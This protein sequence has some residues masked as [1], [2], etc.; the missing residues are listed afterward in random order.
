MTWG[1]CDDG[2]LAGRSSQPGVDCKWTSEALCMREGKLDGWRRPTY[3]YTYTPVHPAPPRTSNAAGLFILRSAHPATNG[4]T[5]RY[6]RG[7]CA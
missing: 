7:G 3:I 6:G 5:R 4:A 2:W 1:A